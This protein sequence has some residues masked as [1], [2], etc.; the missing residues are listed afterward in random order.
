MLLHKN[1][2]S[3]QGSTPFAHCCVSL[4]LLVV[5]PV[6]CVVSDAG[7]KDADAAVAGTRCRSDE[8]KMER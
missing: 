3:P 6:F 8:H 5:A 4:L 7:A 1:G 2:A